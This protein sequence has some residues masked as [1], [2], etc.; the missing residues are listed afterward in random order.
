MKQQSVGKHVATTLSWFRA[1]ASF[2]F[3]VNTACLTE[4]QQ[5]RGIEPT[6]YHN[7][8]K[9]AYHY[10]TDA[11]NINFVKNYLCK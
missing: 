11:E 9:H 10:T 3:L 8:S 1:N 6:I 4:K 5:D 7:R 2:L